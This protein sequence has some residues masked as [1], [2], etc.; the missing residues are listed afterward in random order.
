MTTP[1]NPS[2]RVI[3]S[4]HFTRSIEAEVD[5]D[6]YSLACRRTFDGQ[7]YCGLVICVSEIDRIIIHLFVNG[8]LVGVNGAESIVWGVFFRFIV[9]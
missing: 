7:T 3:A 2:L 6:A 4:N 1:I 8:S 9:I 5:I